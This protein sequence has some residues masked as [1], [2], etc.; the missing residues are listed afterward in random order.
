MNQLRYLCASSVPAFPLAILVYLSK[1]VLYASKYQNLSVS[2]LVQCVCRLRNSLSGNGSQTC[3]DSSTNDGTDIIHYYQS[4]VGQLSDGI[5]SK[6]LSSES[7][8]PS[9]ETTFEKTNG[10]FNCDPAFN[11]FKF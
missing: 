7:R 11:Y 3:E 9:I 8:V 5:I 1:I 4:L 2:R 6:S 10:R